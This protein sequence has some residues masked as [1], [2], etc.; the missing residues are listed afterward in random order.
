MEFDDFI[1]W[2]KMIFGELDGNSLNIIKKTFLLS[3]DTAD[4]PPLFLINQ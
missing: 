2:I 3:S 4:F 1:T